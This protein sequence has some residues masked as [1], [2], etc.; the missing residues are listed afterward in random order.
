MS[1]ET[2]LTNARIVAPDEVFRGTLVLRA[3][4]IAALALGRSRCPGAIDCDGDL[5]L[6]GLIELHTDNLEKHAAPRPGVRWPS[7]GAVL[8]HDAQIAAAG[9]T[10]VCDAITIGDIWGDPARGDVLQ[11]LVAALATASADALLRSDHLLH[12]RAE[13]SHANLLPQFEALVADAQVRVVTL[14]DHTPGQRQFADEAA[15]RRYYQGKNRLSDAEMDRLMDRH[16][17]AQR[18]HAGPNRAR[19]AALARERGLLIGS[20][21]DASAAHVDEAADTGARFAEFPTTIEAARHARQRGIAVLLG[22]PNAVRGGSH[23]GNVS[24]LTL[25]AAG[26]CDILSSDYVPASLAH[27]MLRLT[28]DAG[29]AL[30]AAVATATSTPAALLGLGDRGR[31]AVGLRADLVRLRDRGDTPVPRAVW[32]G[33]ARIA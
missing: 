14:M 29:M 19:V 1:Y 13:T 28:Q 22:A 3:G 4:R 31:I 30:H 24:A 32:R 7:L 17:D 9:I 2:I 6:P 26:H 5:L 10:T 25:A 16:R 8:A 21:D 23:S 33:G 20:H 15:Y 12:L 11:D 27:G 18:R